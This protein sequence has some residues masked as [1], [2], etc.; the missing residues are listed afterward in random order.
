MEKATVDLSLEDE[1]EDTLQLRVDSVEKD[2]TYE[3]CFV[4]IF[5]TSSV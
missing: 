2:L 1:E 5:L 3:N 4:G